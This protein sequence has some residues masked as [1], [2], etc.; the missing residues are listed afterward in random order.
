MVPAAAV[1]LLGAAASAIV[2]CETVSGRL[3]KRLES[4]MRAPVPPTEVCTTFR[5]DMFA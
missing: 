4:W 3:P 1:G 2:A 5:I